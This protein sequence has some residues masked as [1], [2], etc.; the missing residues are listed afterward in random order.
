MSGRMR[1]KQF[2]VSNFVRNR[3]CIVCGIEYRPTW[4]RQTTCGT[5]DCKRVLN[6]TR[7][8]DATGSKFALLYLKNKISRDELL[9]YRQKKK[10][11]TQQQRKMPVEKLLK[12]VGYYDDKSDEK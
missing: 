10:K 3:R 4:R 1:H 5:K 11:L 12:L 6:S 7:I 9:D 2:L 8:K